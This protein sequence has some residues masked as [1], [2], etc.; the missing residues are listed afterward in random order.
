MHEIQIPN[1][2]EPGQWFIVFHRTSRSRILSWLSFG[3][4][5][6]VSAFG[7]CPGLKVWMLY[8]VQ[9]AGTRIM[10]V[11][12]DAIMAWTQGC[13]VVKIDRVNHRMGLSS[14]FGFYCVNAVKHLLGLKCVAVTPNQLYRHVIRHGGILI[15]EHRQQQRSATAASGRPDAANRAA[16]GAG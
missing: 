10:L 14:R 11:N 3:E 12:K 7:Y 5:K 8:D 16:A 2:I 13:D 9:W 1:C 4:L 15:S 6:H